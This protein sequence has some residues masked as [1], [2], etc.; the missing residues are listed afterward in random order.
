M[1]RVYHS[2]AGDYV[3]LCYAT[4]HRGEHRPVEICT[5]GAHVLTGRRPTVSR[6]VVSSERCQRCGDLL[7]GEDRGYATCAWCRSGQGEAE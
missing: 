1:C 6:Q 5:W 7:I 3:R 4:G 2:K